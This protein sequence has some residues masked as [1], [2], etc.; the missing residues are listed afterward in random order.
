[1]TTKTL[2]DEKL[3]LKIAKE[4]DKPIKYVREQISKKARR[5]GISSEAE[6]IVW[7][8]DL[9]IGTAYAF[10]KLDPHKQD[11][12]RSVQNH[13]L[14]KPES[15][16]RSIGGKK[17]KTTQVADPIVTAANYLL[18]DTEL[19]SRCIDLLRSKRHQDR[20][21]REATVVLENRI[22]LLGGVTERLR[23]APL[24]SRVLNPDPLK[25]ILVVS[26]E[27]SEQ[28]GF[29]NICHGVILSFRNKAHHAIDDKIGREDALKF[30]GFVDVILGML[31]T[32]TKRE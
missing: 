25:A 29:H 23:P 5:A 6:Q 18:T 9:G 4:I 27:S 20:V 13:P 32:A 7:A 31:S 14:R 10:R 30:C 3:L 19:R 26:S 11:E 12:V 2:L 17:D 22:R 28:Q 21:F 24:V 16:S 15:K 8:R 1:M